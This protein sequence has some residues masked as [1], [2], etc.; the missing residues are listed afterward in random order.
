MVNHRP[1]A[2]VGDERVT[3]GYTFITYR[4][5]LTTYRRGWPHGVGWGGGAGVGDGETVAA[6]GTPEH[7]ELRLTCL[8]LCLVVL[9]ACG[10]AASSEPDMPIV[11]TGYVVETGDGTVLCEDAA[12]ESAPPQCEG[13]PLE[14]W[15]WT[16]VQYAA[17]SE[18]GRW[19]EFCFEGRRN[20]DASISVESDPR[21]AGTCDE[22]EVAGHVS[23]VEAA[24]GEAFVCLGP[25]DPQDPISCGSGSV[26]QRDDVRLPIAGWQ[27]PAGADIVEV[28]GARQAGF[29]VHGVIDDGRLVLTREPEPTPREDPPPTSPAACGEF[30]AVVP[31]PP[32][33]AR[34]ADVQLD[35]PVATAAQ[36]SERH[37]EFAQH[38]LADGTLI[39]WL[40]VDDPSLLPA[41]QRWAG[42][43]KV[44]VHAVFAPVERR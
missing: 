17:G 36:E 37:D 32:D 14:S 26:S 9:S 35:G 22:S 29:E 1:H 20:T 5:W 30:V 18:G 2:P 6:F 42:E 34:C 19:G 3:S 39:V 8:A 40:R 33:D 13:T 27:W 11:L 43:E 12:A 28:D 7:M 38:Y 16:Q 25:F 21:P 15:E 4:Q 44:E 31:S 41:L 24:D 10:S 23:V